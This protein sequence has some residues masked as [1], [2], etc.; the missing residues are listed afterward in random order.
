M[1]VRYGSG[2]FAKELW[3]KNSRYAMNAA[4]SAETIHV[5]Q[6]HH[7]KFD[8]GV[9]SVAYHPTKSFVATSGADSIIKL[10]Q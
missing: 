2:M 1:T 9:L 8:E 5:I 4:V 7:R 3:C 6:A 10:Y